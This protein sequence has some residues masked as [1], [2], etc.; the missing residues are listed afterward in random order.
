MTN[1]IPKV[2][3]DL[4]KKKKVRTPPRLMNRP[5]E[6]GL[7]MVLIEQEIARLRQQILVVSPEDFALTKELFDILKVPY[8]QAPLEAET[9]CAD[10]CKRSLVAAVLSEDTDVLA[11]GA[12]VFLSKIDTATDNCVQ[13]NHSTLLE[14]LELTY[15]E[16]LD[17]CIMCGTDYN[18]N[19][20]RIGPEKAY[21]LIKQ[22]RNI[23]E[24][25]K[26]TKHDI[27]ILNHIR[28]RE[29]FK[30]YEQF[31]VVIPYCGAPDF[32]K[33][34]QFMERYKIR[35]NLES[36]RKAFVRTVLAFEEEGPAEPSREDLEIDHTE[37]I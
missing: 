12:P 17:L 9:T 13:I 5:R 29:L 24:I 22:Y 37:K 6:T 7:N 34:V 19:I 30:E 31:D 8:Y 10:L 3:L 35:V 15:D 23:D 4:N 11:Y 20:F 32:E 27:S 26:R 33:L 25:A 28:G 18:K 16:F 2:L 14:G 21:K 36:L 1:E